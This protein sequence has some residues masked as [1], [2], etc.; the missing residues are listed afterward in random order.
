MMGK[1]GHDD[2]CMAKA[3]VH[4]QIDAP[5]CM[6]ATG[7]NASVHRQKLL[8]PLV[9]TPTHFPDTTVKGDR[10][11]G[12]W[13]RTWTGPTPVSPPS[14]IW[15]ARCVDLTQGDGWMGEWLKW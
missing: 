15:A 2:T 13:M 5:A 11:C 6:Y 1:F 3:S 8:T 7:E 4:R 10:R 12:W 14:S 9:H